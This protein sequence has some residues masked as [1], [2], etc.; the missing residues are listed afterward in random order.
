[1]RLPAL[2][3]ILLFVFSILIDW[4]IW[5]QIRRTARRGSRWPA[6]Y[7]AGS[8]LCW[9]FLV[10]TISLPRRDA[11]EGILTVMWMLYSYL[12]VYAA[13]LMIALCA[14]LGRL[15]QIGR[16]RKWNAALWVGCPAAAI[17]FAAM[18]WGVA[19]TRH[20]IE[21]VPVTVT[22]PKLPQAFDGYRIAQISDLHVGTWGTDTTFIAR[23]VDRVNSLQPDLIVFTGDIVNRQTSE[24]QPFLAT[25]SRLKA[26][27][28]VLSVLGN[29]DYGDYVDWQT[30]ADRE[31]NNRLLV[32]QQGQM[33]WHMLNNDHTFLL[34]GNDSIAVIGVEN[35]GEPPFHQYGRLEDAYPAP[36]DPLGSLNDNRYKILLTH[37]PEH[38]NRQVSH[39]TNIDL[40]LSG[41]T[42]AM[43]MEIKLGSWRWSP[44]ALRYEQWGGLYERLNDRGEPTSLYVNIGAGEVAMPYRIGAIPEITLITL[45]R[46]P[47]TADAK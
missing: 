21:V 29:H 4:A 2:A 13:K 24:L 14:V 47:R 45:R 39:A 44:S 38:W 12:T 23:L 34:R 15:G 20:N 36:C 8:L 31:A 43:Q 9:A 10:V 42:H 7:A 41:H 35:W 3:I 17:V 19:V 30:P 1:M 22:S 37:N 26:S 11:G 32:R 5:A 33:G 6:V 28:G 27:D 16:R 18:W 46:G 40:S 25:L